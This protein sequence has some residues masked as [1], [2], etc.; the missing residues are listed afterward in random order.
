MSNVDDQSHHIEIDLALAESV[1]DITKNPIFLW[2]AIRQCLI[3]GHPLSEAT[4]AYLI[5]VADKLLEQAISNEKIHD[6]A[7]AVREAVF[8]P[9]AKAGGPGSPYSDYRRDWPRIKIAIEIDERCSGFHIEQLDADGSKEIL[10]TNSKVGALI[11]DYAK[12]HNM[13]EET[14]RKSYYEW[15]KAFAHYPSSQK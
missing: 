9:V 11:R 8:G 7:E 5:K 1:F 3:S 14:A 4:S 12:E 13:G 6:V 15:K 2:K 10:D